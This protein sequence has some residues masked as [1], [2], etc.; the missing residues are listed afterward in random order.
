MKSTF[1]FKKALFL[2]VA[3]C[4]LNSYAESFIYNRKEFETIDGM[5]NCVKFK[6]IPNKSSIIGPLHLDKPAQREV[7]RKTV[8]YEIIE[9]GDNA[10]SGNENITDITFSP[11]LKKI[12]KNAFANMDA[13][14]TLDFGN[15]TAGIEIGDNAFSNNTSL[16][17]ININTTGALKIGD[18]AFQ[19][20][21]QL[22]N[23]VFNVTSQPPA[24]AS[25]IEV[26]SNAFAYCNQLHSIK[27][28]STGLSIQDKSCFT[29]CDEVTTLYL[30]SIITYYGENALEHLSCLNDIYVLGNKPK[31]Q[32]FNFGYIDK[33]STEEEGVSVYKSVTAHF[34][35]SWKSIFRKL[36]KPWCYFEDYDF[37]AGPQH[38]SMPAMTTQP[39]NA[40]FD[41]QAQYNND[42]LTKVQTN[43][44]LHF[45]INSKQFAKKLYNVRK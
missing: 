20:C 37:V 21:T 22:G 5:D 19:N 15:N 24:Q 2:G 3:L 43:E 4:S 45:T 8:Y 26:S 41:S 44:I 9:I 17:S 18:G 28:N 10:L 16:T 39:L 31:D 25:L 29:G 11:A 36:P 38:S 34:P 30:P 40:T 12:G 35:D 32:K 27:F 14:E 13:L 23:A 33:L 6:G 7:N 1:H 42:I